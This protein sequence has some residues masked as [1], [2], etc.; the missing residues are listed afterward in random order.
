MLKQDKPLE[1]EIDNKGNAI[2]TSS[3]RM[4]GFNIYEIEQEL[5]STA[6]SIQDAYKK[7]F[8]SCP[9]DKNCEFCN[10]YVYGL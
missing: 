10:E 3:S 4:D 6:K 7:G 5:V 1:F 2:C 8:K 9:I